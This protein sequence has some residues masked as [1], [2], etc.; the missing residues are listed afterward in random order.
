[1]AEQPV[2]AREID[3]LLNDFDRA[4]NNMRVGRPGAYVPR[5]NGKLANFFVKTAPRNRERDFAY[6]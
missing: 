2:Y 6:V 4:V 5:V 1:M 3:R